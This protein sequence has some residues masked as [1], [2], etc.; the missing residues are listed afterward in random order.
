MKSLHMSL[1]ARSYPTPK[2]T[3]QKQPC[4]VCS[5]HGICWIFLS[6]ICTLADRLIL[7]R[8]MASRARLLWNVRT[9]MECNVL[10]IAMKFFTSLI[11]NVCTETQLIF[12][13]LC[14]HSLTKPFYNVC[15]W[16]DFRCSV[17]YTRCLAKHIC[18]V[19]VLMAIN[20]PYK[21]LYAL[22]REAQ[23]CACLL[24]PLSVSLL[25]GVHKK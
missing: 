16:T 15:T 7:I 12:L 18:C 23:N 21:S 5:F 20:D 8:V 22:L 1:L 17:L 19:C 9:Q 6:C 13:I 25:F 11:C 24:T 2:E 10:I 14:M 3:P 4:H